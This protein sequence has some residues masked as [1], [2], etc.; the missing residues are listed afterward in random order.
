MEDNM[1]IKFLEHDGRCKWLNKIFLDQLIPMM[2]ES[3]SKGD[4]KICL[5]KDWISNDNGRVGLDLDWLASL[6]VEVFETYKDITDNSYTVVN[7]GYDSIV[8]EEHILK[9][10]GVKIIDKPCPFVRKVRTH[11][12]TADP[13]YQYV[14]LCEPTHIIIKNFKSIFPEDLILV[15][16]ENYK[17]RIVEQENGKPLCL[18]PYVTFLPKQVQEVFSFIEENFSERENKFLNTS[19]MWVASKFSPVVEINSIPDEELEDIKDAVIITTPGSVNKSLISLSIT[20]QD[21]GLNVVIVSS[22][23][24]Y[25]SYEKEHRNDSILLVRSPIPNEAEAPIMEYIQS[26]EKVSAM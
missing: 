26:K 12:E 23:E 21:R 8:N 16:T 5:I 25:V 9:E 11:L 7:S 6:K 1:K 10:K 13:N 2:Q 24:D 3:K 14:L 20:C 22:L 19:C 4:G 17:E 15:Q 18:L